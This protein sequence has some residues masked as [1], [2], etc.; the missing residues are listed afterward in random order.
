MNI[1][2]PP[3]SLEVNKI[4]FPFPLTLKHSILSLVK[5]PETEHQNSSNS[6]IKNIKMAG[7]YSIID[8]FYSVSSKLLDETQ[9]QG[10]AAFIVS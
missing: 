7:K 2:V 6:N 1:T 10:L 4:F 3:R 5:T 8:C 9:D